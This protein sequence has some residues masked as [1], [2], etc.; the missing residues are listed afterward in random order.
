MEL[1]FGLLGG[2]AIFIF[3]MQS[4]SEGLQKAAA[5]RMRRILE[6][7]TSI[8]IIGVVVGALVTSIIQSSS[9]TT[10]M[11]VGFV[12]ASLMTLKQAISVIMGAN[13]G[14]TMTAQLISFKL[15]HF[16]LP[17]IALGFMINFFSK[18][19][20]QKYLGQVI[21]GFGLLLLGM[22]IMKDAMVPLREYEGFKNFIISFGQYPLLGVGVGVLMTVAIQSSSATIG[23][24]IAMASEGLVPLSSAIPILLGD[25]IGTCIT[26]MFASIGTNINARRA[27]MGH[28]MFNVIGTILVLILLPI[29]KE[30]VI[31]ISSAD[32]SRQIANAHTSFNIFNTV[33][34][35]PFINLL[36]KAVLKI[37][38]G[39]AELEQ[40]AVVYL[41]ERM[42]NTPSVAISLATK[43][44]VRMARLAQENVQEAMK[45]F[46]QKDAEVLKKVYEREEVIDKLEDEITAY[47][48]KVAA[49]KGMT[50]ESSKR[51]TGLLHAVNDIE[52]VGDHAENI[53]QMT[54]NRIEKNLPFSEQALTELQKMNELVVHAFELSIESLENEDFQ[55]AKEVIKMEKQIDQMEKHLRN[56]HIGRLNGGRCFPHSG[57][58][59]LDIISNMERVGDHSHNI[60][61]FVLDELKT[62]QP[63]KNETEEPADNS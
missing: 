56:S 62:V 10:V 18:R 31:T 41:D 58:I 25:N 38:P 39:D 55:K 61:A 21:F 28:V 15:T 29:F 47:L 14:T 59:F 42:I 30:F 1:I 44:V 13:I 16:I 6:I 52:R 48:A 53:A 40:G 54:E 33:L 43:E 7:L 63:P 51:H 22:D 3:G 57:V 9:A 36:V 20:T 46:F 19:K 35:L 50:A 45:G 34:M 17:I 49:H 32:I 8:P 5:N 37:I 26:A 23:I 4:M 27:A 11:V 2:L 24:L 60:A 12:N